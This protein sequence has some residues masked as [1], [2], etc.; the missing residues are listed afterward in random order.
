M[1]P[2]GCTQPRPERF[3]GA[4]HGHGHGPRE[5]G[6]EM[7]AG[8]GTVGPERGRTFQSTGELN[9]SMLV[10]G[11]WWKSSRLAHVWAGPRGDEQHEQRLAPKNKLNGHWKSQPNHSCSSRRRRSASPLHPSACRAHPKAPQPRLLQTTHRRR[12]A[13]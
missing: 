5:A 9:N 3:Y 11:D 13:F 6:Q 7:Q 2:A 10:H 8:G 4:H 1:Q 12:L